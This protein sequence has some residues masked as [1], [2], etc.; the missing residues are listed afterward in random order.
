MA[1]MR[2]NR[3][4]LEELKT[5]LRELLEPNREHFLAPSKISTSDLTMELR[6]KGWA[7]NS[8]TNAK[9]LRVLGEMRDAGEVVAS[10]GH[11]AYGAAY[12]SLR[13]K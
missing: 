6:R 8:L 4:G 3:Q 11:G 9:V 10:Y 1:I 2:T 12:W 7:W 13:R 5:D